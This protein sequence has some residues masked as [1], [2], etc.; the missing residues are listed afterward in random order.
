ME[1][2]TRKITQMDRTFI[3]MITFYTNDHLIQMVNIIEGNIP[4]R[5]GIGSP[6]LEYINQAVKYAGNNNYF[7]MKR[8]IIEREGERE[9]ESL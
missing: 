9:M 6:R 3:Q 4:V 5:T 8:M 1:D 7:A 2:K